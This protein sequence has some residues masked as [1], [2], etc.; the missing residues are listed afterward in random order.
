MQKQD[1]EILVEQLKE[2][3]RA[4]KEGGAGRGTGRRSRGTGIGG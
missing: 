4:L 1:L 2:Q 3:I